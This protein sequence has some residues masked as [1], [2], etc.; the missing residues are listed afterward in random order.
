MDDVIEKQKE[1]FG[2]LKDTI[3]AMLVNEKG[4]LIGACQSAV[5]DELAGVWVVKVIEAEFVKQLKGERGELEAETKRAGAAAAAATAA[6]AAEQELLRTRTSAATATPIGDSP[7]RVTPG[8]GGESG[9]KR[10][11]AKEIA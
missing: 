10:S 1:E 8:Q 7:A 3:I 9:K 11:G 6:A 2:K 5:Y 4:M